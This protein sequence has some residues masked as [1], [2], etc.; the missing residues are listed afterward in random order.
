MEGKPHWSEPRHRDVEELLKKIESLGW[1]VK[2]CE[3]THD[4]DGMV[5][6]DLNLFKPDENTVF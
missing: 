5:K 4:L 6:V 2:V 1:G 3:L